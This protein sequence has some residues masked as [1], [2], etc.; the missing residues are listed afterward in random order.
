MLNC[1]ID[2]DVL[3]DASFVE[4]DMWGSNAIEYVMAH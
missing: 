3:E 1:I 2:G 4:L